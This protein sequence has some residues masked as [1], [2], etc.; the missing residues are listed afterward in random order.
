MH[1]NTTNNRIILAIL[2]HGE[3]I[4]FP[5]VVLFGSNMTNIDVQRFYIFCLKEEFEEEKRKSKMLETVLVDQLC[6][7]AMIEVNIV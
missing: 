4:S 7:Y 2:L 5:G 6:R 3:K 1:N